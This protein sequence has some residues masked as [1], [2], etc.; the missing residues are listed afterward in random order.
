MIDWNKP[1]E[2]NAG[3]VQKLSHRGNSLVRVQIYD[4][5]FDACKMTGKPLR[6]MMLNEDRCTV[7]NKKSNRDK[8][9]DIGRKALES[10]IVNSSITGNIVDAL[11]EAGLIT[12]D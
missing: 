4:V 1:L 2:C 5:S 10:S 9:I 12:D 3:D 6:N 11:I 7:R 8:A